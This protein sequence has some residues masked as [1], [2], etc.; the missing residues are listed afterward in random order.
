MMREQTEEKLSAFLLTAVE[1]FTLKALLEYLGESSGRAARDELAEYLTFN[2]SAF[3]NPSLN[4]EEEETWITR[5]GLFTGKSVIVVPTKEEIADGILIPGSRLV[6]FYDASIL[7]NE[8]EFRYKGQPLSRLVLEVSPEEVYPHYSMFGEEYVP[9]YLALDNDENA[10]LFSPSD[11]EDPAEFP[12]SVV[13]M[14]T[15][16]WDSHFKPGDRVVATAVDWAKGIFEVSALAEE[17]LDRAANAKWLADFEECL[18]RSFELYGASTAIDEQMTFAW[19]LGQDCLFTPHAASIAEFLKWTKR[20]SIEP[21]GIETR[22]WRAGE[23]ITAQGSWDMPM[24]TVPTSVTEEIFFHLGMPYNDL[25]LDSYVLD[26]LFRKEKGVKQVLSRIFPS[27]AGIAALCVPILERE[28]S[29]FHED[30][31]SDYNWFAD[32]DNAVLRNRYVELHNA[33]ANFVW[34]LKASKIKSEAVPDQGAVVLHQLLNH[35]VSGLEA[36]DADYFASVEEREKPLELKR[37]G[38]DQE[39]LWASIESMEDSFFDIKTVILDALPELK[40][41]NFSLLDRNEETPDE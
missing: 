34:M 20:I 30:F 2:Q 7:P 19:F 41:Q 18:L 32:H 27:R 38:D 11:Y 21:Y 37:R 23:A 5:A 36:L 4:D 22:L 29:R 8:L 15:M 28:L 13:N 17:D 35:A 25:V 9:Q 1:P 26:A 40:K 12:V 24:V 6:P 10:E 31:S 16:Y 33:L 39:S 3:M 14:R